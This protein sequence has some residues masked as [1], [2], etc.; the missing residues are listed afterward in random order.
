MVAAAS[1]I[2]YL[3]A[4]QNRKEWSII[5]A[6]SQFD[7]PWYW[8]K[9]SEAM[10]AAVAF[11]QFETETGASAQELQK[12]QAVAEQTNQLYDQILEKRGKK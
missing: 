12:W 4:I 10:N 3:D 11:K 9:I 6:S 1:L 8:T 2:P 5:F 7:L